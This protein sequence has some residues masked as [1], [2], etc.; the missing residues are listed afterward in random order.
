MKERYLFKEDVI[1]HPGKWT[2]VNYS[3]SA[4]W[5]GPAQLKVL[6]TVEEEKDPVVH[7]KDM[8]GKIVWVVPASDKCKLLYGIVSVQG[9]ECT[10]WVMQEDE[11]I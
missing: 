10:W 3:G 9:P 11:K 8:V 4:N 6:C 7:I 5:A 1:R 2:A